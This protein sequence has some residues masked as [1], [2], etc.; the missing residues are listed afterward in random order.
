MNLRPLRPLAGALTALA[1]AAAGAGAAMADLPVGA[2]AEGRPALQRPP[3][4]EE[5][6]KVRRSKALALERQRAL[7]ETAQLL[8]PSPV[9]VERYTLDIR[10]IPPPMKRVQGTVRIQARVVAAPLGTLVV[11]LYDNMAISSIVTGSGTPLS[12]SRASNLVTITLDRAYSPGELVDLTIAYGGTPV[13]ANFGGYAFSF[14]THGS[15]GAPI[16]SS[17]SEPDFAP[18][19]WP[20]IDRPDDKAIVDMDL[21]V[22][23]TLV[24]VSNGV[25]TETIDNGDGTRTYRWRSSYPISTYLVSVAVSNYVTWTDYYTPVTGGPVMPVQNWVYPEHL[26]SAQTDLSVIVPQ[27]TFFSGL[28][29]EYPFVDEKYGHA[30]FPFNGG[31]EHQTAT[32]YGAVLIRGD[33]RYDWVAAHELAH[34]WWGDAVGPAEWPE[35]WLNE[36]FATYSEALWQEHLGGTSAY[37]NYIASLDSRP[38]CGTIYAPPVTCD[39]FGNTVYDKGAWVLHMLR[40]LVGDTAFFQGLRDYY[41]AY[42]G[43][44]ATTPLFKE[45]METASGIDLDPFLNRWIYATGEPSYRFGWTSA[46]TSGGYVTHVRIEQVQG[47]LEFTMPVDIRVTYPG[48]VQTFVV[49]NS[50]LAQD[51][52]LPPVTAAPTAVAFDPDAWI[53]KTLEIIPLADADADGVPDTADNCVQM[54]NPAQPDLDGDGAGDACDPDIDGD[55]RANGQDCAPADASVADPPAEATNLMLAGGASA[56]LTWTP[57]SGAGTSW[58]SEV[59]R[60]SLLQMRLDGGTLGA[61]CLANALEMPQYTDV[62][63]P[64]GGDGYYYHVRARNAC[65]PGSLGLASSGA[66]R[67]SIPCP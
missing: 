61:T 23:N 35:I 45:V 44:N 20:C 31:M 6:Q 58:S 16:I 52:A 67:P 22:P 53:L 13:V 41:T 46:A 55:G 64:P 9:D 48:G 47:S 63:D 17:L 50:G 25:L 5:R 30:I 42:N 1:L 3:T 21:T 29:G 7:M 34:Q 10:V 27:L 39:L 40:H 36:G 19:W 33:H 37:R 56:D 14:G 66:P 12:S 24:G 2:P 38:F 26:A 32:S 54:A 43:S 49:Q 59:V 57:P 4:Q 28:F 15:P 65:G 51:V 11:G 62:D 8:A 60:G 18:V